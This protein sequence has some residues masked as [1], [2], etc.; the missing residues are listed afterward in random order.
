M[1]YTLENDFIAIE[2][3]DIG[4]E[5]FSLKTKSDGFEYLWQGDPEYWSGRAYN[6]FPICGRLTE[7]KYTYRGKTYEMNLHGFARKTKYTYVGKTDNT[8]TFELVSDD[9]SRAVYPFDFRLVI[10]YE[11]DGSTVKTVFEVYNT[12]SDE[13][14]Y[15]I[16][17]HPGFNLPLNSG[18]SF[19]DYVLDFGESRTDVKKNV[20]SETCYLLPESED[21]P[22]EDGHLLPLRHSMFDNDAIFL[23]NTTGDVTLRCVNGTGKSVNVHFPE[24]KYVGFWHKPLTSAPYVCIEPWTSVPAYDGVID[25]FDTKRDMM[26]LAPGGCYKSDF[27]VT[28][29]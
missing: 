13:L 1:I 20:M 11:L 18:E 29:K 2:V 9:V 3:N 4:A 26:R 12:G 19:E 24:M 25:D 15:A 23:Y 28:V 5:L 8:M 6:L 10:R 27:T 22:L 16:G 21:F 7:G 14:I 17:G